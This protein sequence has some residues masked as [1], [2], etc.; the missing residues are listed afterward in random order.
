MSKFEN[1]LETRDYNF[2]LCE[3]IEEKDIVG[4][5]NNMKG[6]IFPGFVDPVC[7]LKAY[8]AEKICNIHDYLEKLLT[9][10]ETV[11]NVKHDIEKTIEEFFEN[12]D[13]FKQMYKHYL[14]VTQLRNLKLKSF[15]VIQA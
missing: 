9:G 14:M 6:L 3:I 10:I 2:S 13:K 12:I 7:D 5:I 15:Y 4:F 8:I 11:T 1:W